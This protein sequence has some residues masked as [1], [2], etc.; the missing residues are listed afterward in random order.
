MS[1]FPAGQNLFQSN[2]SPYFKLIKEEYNIFYKASLLIPTEKQSI[3]WA[4]YAFWRELMPFEYWNAVEGQSHFISKWKMLL[5]FE[6]NYQENLSMS[7]NAWLDLQNHFDQNAKNLVLKVLNALEICQS[8]IR[9]H[10]QEDLACFLEYLGGSV[11]LASFYILFFNS[12]P[13]SQNEE[14]IFDANILNSL[15]YLG[16]GILWWELLKENNLS[17]TQGKLFIPIVDL[18]NFGYKE[19]DFL[20]GRKNQ[21]IKQLTKF[22]LDKIIK[23]LE[24]AIFSMQQNDEPNLKNLKEIISVL[25]KHYIDEINLALSSDWTLEDK[26]TPTQLANSNNWLINGLTKWVKGLN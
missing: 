24:Q 25:S 7:V 13:A 9:F 21:E 16:S 11:S 22:E 15:N 14:I 18:Q 6:R 3:A 19:E 23:Y 5:F 4:L 20:N 26:S 2:N 8:N 12:N 1:S 17:L 10:L